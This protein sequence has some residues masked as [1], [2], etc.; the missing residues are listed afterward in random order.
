MLLRQVQARPLQGHHLRALWRRGHALEGAAR[1]DG[2]HRARRAGHAHLVLQ[3][4]PEPARLPPRPRAEE[5]REGHL[6]RGPHHHL[7]RRRPP[8][9]GS[10][11]ARGRHP[12]RDRRHREGARAR[13]PKAR[14]GV[15]GGA[16]RPRVTRREEERAR[17]RGEGPQQGLRGCPRARRRRDRLLEDGLGHVPRA[18]AQA[19]RRRR[20]GV[21]RAAGPLPGVLLRRHGRRGGQ[22]PD[23][24]HRHGAR[25]AVAQGDH[26]HRQGSAQG[27]GD[28]AAQGDL[29]VQPPSTRT[30][31]RST[32]RWAWC[33][34]RCR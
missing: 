6:L 10:R 19:A 31:A 12:R 1:A 24:A 20:A 26:R 34:T 17:A 5:P 25:G 15:R 13:A 33:S 4:C 18:L 9:H 28:Q 27:Q 21:A 14:R 11:R 3:G 32:P 8:P 16:R 29:C 2:P 7:G 23:L 22:G 30:A